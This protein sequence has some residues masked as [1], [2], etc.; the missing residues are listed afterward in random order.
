MP[1]G[2]FDR[3]GETGKKTE[4]FTKLIQVPKEVFMDFLQRLTSEVNRMIPNSEARQII[5]ESLAFENANS[6]CKKLI[7]PLKE[8]SAPL[9]EWIRDTIIIDSPDHDYTWI[10]EVISRGLRKIKTSNVI[11]MAPPK[12]R[13][14]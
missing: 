6:L 3:I 8:K 9:E 2:S 10:G 1:H 11:N 5:I 14:P 12:K 13:S 7:R 4:S